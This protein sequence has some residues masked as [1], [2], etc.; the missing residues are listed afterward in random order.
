MCGIAGILSKRVFEG[1]VDRMLAAIAHRGPNEAGTYKDES[2]CFGTVRLSIVDVENGHQ[3]ITEEKTGVVVAFNGEIFNFIELRDE[4]KEKGWGFSTQSDTEVILKLYLQYGQEFV[5]KLNG[6]F[7]IAIWDPRDR[8]LILTRDRFGICPLFYFFNGEELFFGSEIKAIISSERVPRRFNF[9]ALD[10]LYTFWTTVNQHTF[11][12]DIFEVAPGTSLVFKNGDLK[13]VKYWNW[14]FPSLT[15]RSNLSFAETKEAL[16]E[17]LKRSVQLR[18]R[19]D[20]EV[21]SYLSGGLDSS[22]IVALARQYQDGKFRT[23]S[24]G[25]EDESYDER[26]FQK[27]V[28]EHFNTEH[29]SVTVD[30]AAIE[31]VFETVIHHNEAPVFRTAASP[32]LLLSRSVRSAGLKVVLSGEGSDEILLGYD[33]FR[34]L[35]VRKFWARNQ[36]SSIRPQLFRKL[37]AYL[38]QFKNPRYVELVAQ[39]YVST[40]TSDSPFYSHLPRW[41]NNSANKIFFSEMTK[42]R[43]RNYSSEDELGKS[44]PTEFFQ[45]SD[46]DRA[47]YLEIGTLLRGY[48]LSSQADRMTM[49]NSVEGRYPFLDHEFVE[50][51]SRLP[52]KFKLNGLKDKYILRESFK[53]L[54]PSSISSR[55]KIAY[56]APEIRSFIRSDTYVSP[57]VQSYLSEG[58]IKDSTIF[59]SKMMQTLINKAKNSPLGRLGSRDN[60]AFVQALS[61]QMFYEKFIKNK[62]A[63][64]EKI[65]IMVRI[66]KPER[67]V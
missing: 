49:A 34:E 22:A 13:H 19:S 58:I 40:L 62:P 56:Q 30:L 53:G 33:L 39:S 24:V 8:S 5:K 32:L 65:E 38:P 25:F 23:F 28:S 37:Y 15:E 9:K 50:F 26:P 20:V 59:D 14:Q 6:Q 7:G 10:Q 55:P 11:F 17:S 67:K 48:L 16:L 43:L 52:D 42:D 2:I 29:R 18:L 21:G 45:A 47:Q 51:A 61:T 60:M 4:L 54:L 44:L 63:S 64:P 41:M 66:R 1:E 46:L 31:S 35:K 36:E 57:L 3:P 27:I 12:E